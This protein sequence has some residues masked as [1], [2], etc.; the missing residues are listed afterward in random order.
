MS[1]I[2]AAI[3]LDSMT[4]SAY[5]VIESMDASADIFDAHR[6]RLFGIAYRMLGSRADAEDILQETYLRWIESKPSELRSTEAWLATV[7]TRLCIDRLRSAKAEREAYTG[8]WLPEPLVSPGP[9]SPD[10]SVELASD[11]SIA[12]LTVLERLAS[13]E[14]AAFLLHEVFDFDYYEI[15]QIIG[16]NQAACRQI[17]HRAK[18]R[19]QEDRPRYSVSREAHGQLLERFIEAANSGSR[20]WVLSLLADEVRV[21]ADGG[22]KVSSFR[23]VLQGADRVARLYAGLSRK[24]AGRFLYRLAEINGEPGLLRYVDGKL[25]SA[26]S[27]VIDGTQIRAI[28]IVRNPDKLNDI[29]M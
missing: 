16:K 15:A 22:D 17:V 25:E 20:E 18:Q 5:A 24:F 14:R 26:Q 19:V 3:R 11:I 29:P 28:Y 23:K 8:P 9:L 12:F 7:V 27:F 2:F 13:E 10:R 6:P 4:N 1:Q 21:T